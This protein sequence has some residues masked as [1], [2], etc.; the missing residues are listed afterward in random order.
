MTYNQIIKE[1]LKSLRDIKGNLSSVRIKG[2]I[3]DDITN[4]TKFL[5][6]YNPDSIEISNTNVN[7]INY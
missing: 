5:D 6:E 1:N 4:A 7:F 3:L 2:K